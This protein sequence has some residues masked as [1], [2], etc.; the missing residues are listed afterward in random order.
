MHRAVA[1][2]FLFTLIHSASAQSFEQSTFLRLHEQPMSARS[3]AMGGASD[4]L[5]SDASDLAS[6][7]ALVASLKKATLSLS[8][9][10]TQYGVSRY[11][12]DFDTVEAFREARQARTLAHA[13]LAVPVRGAVLAFYYRQDPRLHDRQVAPRPGIEEY[14]PTC[15]DQEHPCSY[16]VGIDEVGFNRREQRYGMS[17]AWERGGL[18]V[19]GG[20]ELRQLDEAYDLVVIGFPG[21]IGRELEMRRVSGQAWVPNAGV[22]WR[23]SPRLAVAAAYNGGGS[24]DRADNRC[25][26]SESNGACVSHYLPVVRGTVKSADAWRASVA[27]VPMERLT[28]TAEA[29]RRNY[30]RTEIAVTSLGP[31]PAVFPIQ[32]ATDLHAG[33][34]YRLR[35]LPV[36]LRAGWWREEPKRARGL[37]DPSEPG[38]HRTYG[39]GV[40]VGSAR[41]DVAYDDVDA[42]SMSRA[43]VGVTW[44]R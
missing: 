43:I 32:N 8:G 19:G 37:Y 5:G 26:A 28:I 40:D 13:A 33:A 41:V 30:G 12:I 31:Q 3:A 22:R 38:E 18:S 17:G 16:L 10:Q 29:V 36:S 2:L 7:P 35:A 6:N 15:L 25:R 34:E 9:T 23:V 4:A 14:F 44:T 24:F 42:P 21:G 11:R 27:I 39:A 20:L 1:T